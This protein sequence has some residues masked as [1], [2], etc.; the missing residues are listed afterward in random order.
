MG[1]IEHK[2][3]KIVGFIKKRTNLFDKTIGLPYMLFSS[4]YNKQI[5][6]KLQKL[7]PKLYIY[8]NE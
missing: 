8:I 1:F 5:T 7:G 6:P 4:T 2:K 3:E